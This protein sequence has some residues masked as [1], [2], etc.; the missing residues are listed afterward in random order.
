MNKFALNLEQFSYMLWTLKLD[1]FYPI[2]KKYIDKI[3]QNSTKCKLG[4]HLLIMVL[5][6]IFTTIPPTVNQHVSA[7]CVLDWKNVYTRVELLHKG[8]T[9]A[10]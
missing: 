8:I 3:L 10:W 2:G 9:I 7:R 5:M 6:S 4:R 1:I